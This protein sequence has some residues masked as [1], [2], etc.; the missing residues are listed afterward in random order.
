MVDK[1]ISSGT[2][3]RKKIA[4]TQQQ[5]EFTEGS[6]LSA[7]RKKY[8]ASGGFF[9][10]FSFELLQLFCGGLNGLVGFGLRSLVYPLFLGGCGRRPAIATRVSISNPQNVFLGDQVLLDES[11]GIDARH[12]SQIVIG[13]RVSIGKFTILSSKGES[14]TLS[15]GVNIGSHCRVA[16]Q[17]KIFIGSSTLIAAYAYIGPGNHMHSPSGSIIDGAMDLRGGVRIENNVWV[18]T[19]ATILDGVTIGEGA[20][21][22]AHSLVTEDVPPWTVVAGVPAKIIKTIEPPSGAKNVEDSQGAICS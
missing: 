1:D 12:N 6:G 8:F 14:I 13:H 2:A 11:V 10:F 15:D 18:G 3:A 19:R 21:V 4:T 20:I 5:R 7:Y 9:R 17:T 16:T 22:G